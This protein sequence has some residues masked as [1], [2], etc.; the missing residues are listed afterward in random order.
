MIKIPDAASIATIWWLETVLGRKCGAST[1]TNVYGALQL[2][3]EAGD[4]P[5][6]IV[7]L[8]CDS[9]ERYLDSYYNADWL[10]ENELDIEPYLKQLEKLEK[11]GMLTQ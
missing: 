11:T 9:G 4:R 6:S 2:M 7:S 1:G 3:A 10:A 5:S 8:I